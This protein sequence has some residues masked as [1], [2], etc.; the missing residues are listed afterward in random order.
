MSLNAN[1]LKKLILNS[2]Q[3]GIL[4]EAQKHENRL[5]L[6]SETEVRKNGANP[7]YNDFLNWVEGFL[8]R[9]KFERFCQLLKNPI[10]TLGISNEIFT[11]LSRI[12]DGQN[13]FYNYEFK[14][15]DLEDDF[16]KYLSEELHDREFFKT[17]GFEQ[18]K[19]GI[20]S[21]LVVDLPKE[22]TGDRL[23][24]RYYFVNSCNIK[25]VSVN[26]KGAIQSIIFELKKDTYAVY[27]SEAYRIYENVNGS[28]VLLLESEHGIGYCPATFFWDKNMK[29]DN[30]ILKKSPLT[31][32]LNLLDRYLAQDTF[33]EHADLYSSYPIVVSMMEK[34][35]FDGCENGYINE[36]YDYFRE[37]TQ[38]WVTKRKQVK[39]QACEGR[40]LIG[41][42]TN[43]KYSAPQTSDAPDLSNPVNIITAE[44]KP[45]E[46]LGTKLA[47]I[48]S[49]IKSEVIGTST[50]LINDQAINEM[51]VMG[52][53]ESRRNVLVTVKESFEKVH[54]F[55]NETVAILRYGDSFLSSTVNYGDEFYLKNTAV[56][57][58][59]YEEAK[60]N[61]E[62]D[63][64]IDSIYK[65]IIQ[66]KY[67]GNKDKIKRAWTLYNLNPMPHNNLEQSEK[68]LNVGAVSMED[69]VIKAR[70]TNF[71]ARF[72]REQSNILF[73]GENLEFSKR[74]E[75]IYS[76][77][78][79]YA[80]ESEQSTISTEEPA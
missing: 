32:S 2:P 38:E 54:K 55:A 42:G 18:L 33:K 37:D 5:A 36:P 68:L 76:Q 22:P 44:T 19:T 34:C 49:K 59:E 43:Y 28:L 75:T 21:V 66:T 15:S 74:I 80:N 11:E 48:E 9:D 4:E 17:Q 52:S 25:H 47:G 78:K 24:P 77:L 63:E 57:Q 50:K 70:F 31:D 40:N 1:K 56:L 14:S 65:Q 51:Q 20:N 6:H 30:S 3:K 60:K 46:Y 12:F 64:E 61:G 72:E 73:F 41:A 16:N 69:F 53:F 27:D 45:L 39:C 62:P 58:K 23:E 29:K 79:V 71:I 26:H 67:R 7:A 10:A 13:S 35:T 8:P